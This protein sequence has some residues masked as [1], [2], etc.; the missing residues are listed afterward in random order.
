MGV[1]RR[2]DGVPEMRVPSP[3]TDLGESG[4]G[5]R[6]GRT[7]CGS[8]THLT[9]DTPESEATHLESSTHFLQRTV[10]RECA[11]LPLIGAANMGQTAKYLSRLIPSPTIHRAAAPAENI[12]TLVPQRRR[13][14]GALEPT[15]GRTREAVF[16]GRRS[17]RIAKVRVHTSCE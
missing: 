11:R 6:R 1:S 3:S 15:G 2:A 10:C 17:R 13:T 14:A 4:T 16:Q 9:F 5:S 7:R 8:T 12:P